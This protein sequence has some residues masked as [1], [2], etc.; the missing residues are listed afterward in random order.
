MEGLLS[1]EGVGMEKPEK[2]R[3]ARREVV[4]SGERPFCVVRAGI[5]AAAGPFHWMTIKSL[6]SALGGLL[7]GPFWDRSFL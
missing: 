3:A 2:A 5:V 6:L 4:R 1:G 7:G